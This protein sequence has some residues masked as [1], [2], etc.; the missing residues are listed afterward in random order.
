MGDAGGSGLLYLGFCVSITIP[1]LSASWSCFATTCASTKRLRVLRYVVPK[2]RAK[3][4]TTSLR[5][6]DAA[7]PE[8]ALSNIPGPVVLGVV[9][10]KAVCVT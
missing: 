3:K 4:R 2:D 5:H 7:A 1:F 10:H 9:Q 8:E 6:P